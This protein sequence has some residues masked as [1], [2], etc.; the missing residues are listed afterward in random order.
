MPRYERSRSEDL[1]NF[2]KEEADRPAT[3]AG[4]QKQQQLPFSHESVGKFLVFQGISEGDFE[5]IF[6]YFVEELESESDTRNELKRI[7]A[8]TKASRQAELKR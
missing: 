2:G 6:S 8:I 4:G 1:L 7:K 5:R 3:G